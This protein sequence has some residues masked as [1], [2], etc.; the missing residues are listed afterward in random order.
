MGK[1]IS[2]ILPNY[3]PNETVR[4]YMLDFL[5]SLS[6]TASSEDYQLISVENGS[7]NQELKDIS[8]IYIH[9]DYPMGYARAVNCGLSLAD[10]DYLLIANNDL[11]L[12]EG[13]LDKMLS[14]YQGGL[15][16]PLDQEF[17]NPEEKI[18]EDMHWFSFVLLDRETF[19]KVGYLDESIPFRFHDQDYSIRV[20]KAGY[21]VRRTGKVIVNHINMA[22]YNAMGRPQ[23]KEE[24]EIMKKRYGACT[25]NEWIKIHKT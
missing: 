20:K 1:K 11:V 24:E 22:T 25:F 18:Y 14:D 23:D 15:L 7:F 9:K 17:Q 16:A 8:D 6:N 5:K 3:T 12:P 21:P 19:K 10:C 2:I 4:G 13:W